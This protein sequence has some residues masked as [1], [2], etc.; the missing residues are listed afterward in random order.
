ME[1]TNTKTQN[2]ACLEFW[3]EQN[4][5]DYSYGQYG[6]TAIDK[7]YVYKK[8]SVG[9]KAIKEFRFT[10]ENRSSIMESIY[11]FLD[12]LGGTNIFGKHEILKSFINHEVVKMSVPIKTYL[13]HQE[14]KIITN[15]N[16]QLTLF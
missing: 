5:N 16:P 8:G 12:Q 10:K 11:K 9:H 3:D 15:T 7:F 4:K 13:N 6:G 1:H 2:D 14:Q